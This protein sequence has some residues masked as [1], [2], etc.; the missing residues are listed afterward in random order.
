MRDLLVVQFEPSCI[1][2]KNHVFIDNWQTIDLTTMEFPAEMLIDYVRVYQR[3]GHTNVG[4]D[5]KAYPTADYIANHPLAYTG[6][7]ST[8]CVKTLFSY[9]TPQSR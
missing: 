7:F 9:P 2:L 8:V 5:P 1:Q 3:T 6:M 4:C